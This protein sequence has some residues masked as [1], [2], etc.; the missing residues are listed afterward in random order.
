MFEK[1]GRWLRNLLVVYLA[2]LG[3][4]SLACLIVIAVL[5][6]AGDG[7]LS[8]GQQQ[9]AGLSLMAMGYAAYLQVAAYLVIAVLFLRFM[10]KAVQQAKGFA[11]PYSYVSPGWAV[12]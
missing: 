7:D 6:G 4:E 9:L 3:V 12:G 11:T 8:G 2:A 1:L 10:Y 5:T